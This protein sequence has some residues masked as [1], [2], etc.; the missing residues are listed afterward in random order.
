MAN[1]SGVAVAVAV[2]VAVL[3]AVGVAVGVWVGG[4]RVGVGLGKGGEVRFIVGVGVVE[5]QPVDNN[6]YVK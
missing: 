1:G 2:A 3:V 6:R 4:W 5:V